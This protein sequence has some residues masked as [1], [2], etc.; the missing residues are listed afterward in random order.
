M[1]RRETIKSI[2]IGGVAGG[3]VLNGCKSES[4][5]DPEVTNQSTDTPGGGYG[6][7]GEE[8]AR[9]QA[10]KAES[11]FTKHEMATIGVLSGIIL[12]ADEASGS[13]LDAEVP[14]FIEF[15]VKDMPHHQV[16][17][18]GG[19]MW[20]DHEA[21]TRFGASFVECSS[22]QQIEIVE[23]IAYPATV[24]PEHSQGARFFSH[25]RDLT[26]TGFYTT[27]IGIDDLG[28]V[29]NVPNVWEGVPEDEL[30]KHGLQYDDFWN[31]R[32]INQETR[33]Q[34][35]VWDENGKLIG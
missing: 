17:M 2:L 6:R 20:L 12:P 27:K 33:T 30:E 13:A 1:D 8:I 22:S 5:E 3:L 16:P 31:S 32:C 25:I 24:K 26:M 34:E 10:L 9:D 11:F 15:I 7:T 19:L 23:D 35:P 14:A 28:Y 18:R 21:S 4:K 29:G